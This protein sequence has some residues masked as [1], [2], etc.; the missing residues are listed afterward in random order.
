MLQAA[1]AHKLLKRVRCQ[2][3]NPNIT[4]LTSLAGVISLLPDHNQSPSMPKQKRNKAPVPQQNPRPIPLAMGEPSFGQS[5]RGLEEE[6]AD[7]PEVQ[8][9]EVL[10]TKAIYP[11]EFERIHG[12]KNAWQVSKGHPPILQI[13]Y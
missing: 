12:R 13:P 4:R 11:D 2:D 6:L 8:R 10:T 5:H 3:I 1:S 9:N 7:Y